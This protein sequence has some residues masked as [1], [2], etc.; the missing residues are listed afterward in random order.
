MLEDAIDNGLARVPGRPPDG[1]CSYHV[2][3]SSLL[4]GTPAVLLADN[5]YYEQKAIGLRDLFELD[6]SLIGVRGAPED[7]TMAAAVLVDGADRSVLVDHLRVASDRVAERF[8]R[9]RAGVA[10]AL[11]E[12]LRGPRVLDSIGRL[13]RKG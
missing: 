11:A 10:A 3:L 1:A 2:T 7:A 6:G 5:E 8:E 12:G 9:G 4:T 13:F